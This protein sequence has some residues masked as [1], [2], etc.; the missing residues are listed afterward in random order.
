MT[1]DHKPEVQSEK[2][3]I[4]ATGRTVTKEIA[5]VN[6]NYFTI[7]IVILYSRFLLLADG[8]L[9]GKRVPLYRIDGQI[10]VSRAIGDSEYKDNYGEGPEKQAVTCVPDI[11]EEDLA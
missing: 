3:R 4:E 5:L 10:S 2:E 6:G 11:T 9:L 8:V 7:C 1:I